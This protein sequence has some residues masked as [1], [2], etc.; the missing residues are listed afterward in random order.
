MITFEQ[1]LQIV[2]SSVTPLQRKVFPCTCLNR[3]L[4]REVHADSDMP[5]FNKAAMDGFACRKADLGNVLD[6]VD[7]IL[8]GHSQKNY[9]DNQCARIMTGPWYPVEPIL[10]S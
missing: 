6:V 1:A 5:P 9:R 8:Q 10:S 3:I 4:A 2:E 7:E